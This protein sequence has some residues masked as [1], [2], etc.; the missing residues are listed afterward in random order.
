MKIVTQTNITAY[1]LLSRGKVRDIYSIDPDTLLI[2]TTDRMSAFDVILSEPVPYKGV[3]LNQ[4]TIFW[5]RMFENIIPNHILYSNINDF[6]HSLD[7]W[8]EELEGRAIIA[9]EAAPLPIECIV[10]G[11]LSGSGWKDYQNTGSIC[12]QKLPP[13]MKESQQIS[14]PLFTPS[15]KAAQGMH[16]ENI[17]FAKAEALTGDETAKSA[18]LTSL[19]LYEAGSSY[20]RDKGI[21]IADTKFELGFINHSLHLIDEVLTPDSSRFWSLKNYEPGKP[22]PSF[23]KQYLRNWLLEQKWNFKAPAP[24]VP[25]EIINETAKRYRDAY[26][27]LTNKT[28]AF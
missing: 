15:T 1:P 9:R 17:N 11:Y 2:I 28:L 19:E 18:M 27:I 5:M 20:A 12:G 22:Q 13:G 14:P 3:I 21:L 16:D 10:R 25:E 6:P 4:L 7:P 26:E 23:D 24:H 8:K